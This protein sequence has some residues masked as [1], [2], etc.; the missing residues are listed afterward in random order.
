MGDKVL[1]VSVDGELTAIFPEIPSDVYGQYCT[2]YAHIGQ[3]GGSS[4]NYWLNAQ[5]PVDESEVSALAAELTNIGYALERIYNPTLKD[6]IAFRRARM[7][8]LR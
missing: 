2:C 1:F 8:C 3:H 4:D 6:A 5:E 7:Q